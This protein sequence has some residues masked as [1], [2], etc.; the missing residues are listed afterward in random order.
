M[1]IHTHLAMLNDYAHLGRLNLN[2][3]IYPAH[4]ALHFNGNH[5]SEA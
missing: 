4:H 5:T 3:S 1:I 2:E